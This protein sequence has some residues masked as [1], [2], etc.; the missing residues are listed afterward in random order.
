MLHLQASGVRRHHSLP[1][2]MRQQV[3]GRQ[4]HHGL[5]EHAA[6]LWASFLTATKRR[7]AAGHTLLH[8]VL[9]H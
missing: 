7:R 8:Q 6:L 3:E 9:A 4:L 5:S 2:S 1:L